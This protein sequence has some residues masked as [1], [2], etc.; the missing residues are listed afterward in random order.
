MACGACGREGL[1]PT[2]DRQGRPQCS[3]CYRNLRAVCARCTKSAL[4]ALRW[5]AGPICSGC[6]ETALA[7]PQTCGGC[8]QL[9]PNVSAA[10]KAAQCPCCAGVRFAYQCT[11]CGCFT[12]SL[13]R[14]R[15]VSCRLMAAIRAVVPAGVS[16][17]VTGF[18]KEALLGNPG[19]SLRILRGAKTGG[20]LHAILAAVP[21]GAQ[22]QD[23]PRRVGARRL[24]PAV[25]VTP[26]QRCD[27]ER[28]TALRTALATAGILPFEPS[29]EHYHRRVAE[30]VD[31]VPSPARLVVRRYV[32]WAVTR[33]LQRRV[34]QGVTLT[35]SIVRWPLERARVA[36]LFTIAVSAQGLALAGVT[37]AHLDTWM[38]ELPSHRAALRAFV[39]WSADHGYV[40][41]ALD[42]EA[43]HSREV[44]SMMDDV[45]RLQLARAMLRK[46][47]EDPPA[48]LA[49]VLVLLF[50]QRVAR[51]SVLKQASVSVD[52][53][54]R[55]AISLAGTPVR[56]RE[57]LAS[58]AVR[59]AAASRERGSVWLFP[60]NQGNRPLSAAR[61]RDRLAQIGLTR[62]LPARN[63]ALGAIAA[64][65]P[66][67]LLA[68]QL[69]LSMTAAA[70]WSKA[71]GAARGD[72]AALRATR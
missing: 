36:T 2:R 47:G 69:G 49:A 66:P 61:L 33:P 54:G 62:V 31:A 65:V 9:R 67:A 63:G 38:N 18:L 60:S 46:P 72:Y 13:R 26:E 44:R 56:L 68:E 64:Q 53:R 17:E 16:A 30:L 4:I 25:R 27:G 52:D 45:D 19:R 7:N 20:R 41:T 34:D 59:V 28:R 48:R 71:A 29:L 57:P 42:V 55:V 10:D 6:V 3:A 22:S 43:S 50:G 14:G 39:R 15:C 8:G 11:D 21:T 32:R 23:K 5:P 35:Q 37:Q 12:R 24:G 1:H 58:L 40:D 51:L 70:A